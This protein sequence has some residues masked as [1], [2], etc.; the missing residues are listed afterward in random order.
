MAGRTVRRPLIG[1]AEACWLS[2]C[3]GARTGN[4]WIEEE[5]IK[6]GLPCCKRTNKFVPQCSK[7]PLLYDLN[8]ELILGQSRPR[9]LLTRGTSRGIEACLA[10]ENCFK[11]N[12][13]AF[14][15]LWQL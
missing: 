4:D 3:A 13:L 7:N 15:G 10:Q 6:L 1:P 12:I 8:S 9:Q 5:S 14:I 11:D 2:A